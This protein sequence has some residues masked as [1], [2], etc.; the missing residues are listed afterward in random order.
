MKR[1]GECSIGGFGG[2]AALEVPDDGKVESTQRADLWTTNR[3]ALSRERGSTQP[4]VKLLRPPRTRSQPRMRQRSFAPIDAPGV[5]LGISQKK[6]ERP[7]AD[8]GSTKRGDR[9]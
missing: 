3:N 2:Y 8:N 5:T 7:D 9:I 4:K 6:P 1:T